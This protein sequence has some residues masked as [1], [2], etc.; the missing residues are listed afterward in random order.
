MI[1]LALQYLYPVADPLRDYT[2][3]DDGS[4]ARLMAWH[5]P[6]PQPTLAELKA[7][8]PAAQ[9]RAAARGELTEM[10]AMLDERY[11]LYTRAVA[12]GNAGDA[13]EIQG[14]IQAILVYMQEVR[15]AAGT[16]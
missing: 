3:G 4:G 12:S 6:S 2:V 11:R 10:Q 13:A 8:L 15:D 14:E 5:L 1:A 16:P 9:A 7:A